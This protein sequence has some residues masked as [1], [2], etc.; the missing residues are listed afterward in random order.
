M[1][2]RRV[3]SA[4]MLAGILTC[5]GLLRAGGDDGQT[6]SAQPA[7]TGKVESVR[8]TRVRL[9]GISLSAGY[10]RFAGPYYGYPFGYFPSYW[11]PFWPYSSAFYNPYSFYPGLYPGFYG[12]GPDKGEVRLRA[13]PQTAEVFLNGAYAGVARDLKTMWLDPGAYNFEVK[14]G[15]RTIFSRRIYVLTGKTLKIEAA[16]ATDQT[17]N[18]P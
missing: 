9:G 12:S 1:D 7:D 2:V 17:E 10:S 3:L 8:R 4:T 6:K 18:Q 16:A 5:P 11:G 15:Q 14:S 13:E